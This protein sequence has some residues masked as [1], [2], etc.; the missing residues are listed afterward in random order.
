[1]YTGIDLPGVNLKQYAPLS[2]S[3]H[4]RKTNVKKNSA[5]AYTHNEINQD[6]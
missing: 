3:D 5:Q 2:F 4:K 6:E 1:M